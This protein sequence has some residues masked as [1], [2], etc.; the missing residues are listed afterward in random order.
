MESQPEMSPELAA[1]TSTSIEFATWHPRFPAGEVEVVW[2]SGPAGAVGCGI[3]FQ[4]P[5]LGALAAGSVGRDGFDAVARAASL[6]EREFNRRVASR[7]MPPAATAS[8]RGAS[9]SFFAPAP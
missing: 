4:H 6:L 7:E 8:L 2:T 9:P 3:R 1:F 5:E